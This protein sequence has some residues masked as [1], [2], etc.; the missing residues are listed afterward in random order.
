MENPMATR[1]LSGFSKREGP[2]Q[3]QFKNKLH[4]PKEE[5]DVLF[6]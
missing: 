1:L 3:K 2:I 5:E 6:F 4:N